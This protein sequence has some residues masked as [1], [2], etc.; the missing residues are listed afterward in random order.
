MWK[1]LDVIGG[2]QRKSKPF[3]LPTPKR[4]RNISEKTV[5]WPVFTGPLERMSKKKEKKKKGR[6]GLKE[7][8]LF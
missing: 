2:C 5:N 3:M 6:N 8:H 4:F 7:N 1:R